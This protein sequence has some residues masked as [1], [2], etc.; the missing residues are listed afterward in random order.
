MLGSTPQA[1]FVHTVSISSVFR[2]HADHGGV[3]VSALLHLMTKAK[4]SR[5]FFGS[6]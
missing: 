4:L 5:T 6:A 3:S 2:A 1:L